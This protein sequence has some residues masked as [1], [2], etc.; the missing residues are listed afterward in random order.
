MRETTAEIFEK[1]NVNRIKVDW[2]GV[3]D[4]ACV[5][6]I[7]R[8]PTATFVPPD[9]SETGH[10]YWY[11]QLKLDIA[12]ELRK[13]FGDDLKLGPQLKR[14]G[15]ETTRR[16]S[17]LINLAMADHAELPVLQDEN[18]P[19]YQ[20]L[21]LGPKGKTMTPAERR[22]ALAGTPSYQTADVRFM[23]DCPNPL[24]ANQPGTGKTIECIGAA[25]EGGMMGLPKLI[26][27]QK[28]ALGS[29][30]RTELNRWQH[31]PVIVATGS[32]AEKMHAMR[33][34]QKLHAK[35]KPF[36]FV[37]NMEM[38]RYK[39]IYR[40]GPS[41]KKE[42]VG[43]EW[44]FPWFSE[45]PWGCV[46]VDELHRVGLNNATTLSSRAV[47]DLTTNKRIALSG[48]PMGGKPMKLW[49]A[50]HW[51]DPKEFSSKWAFANTW[52]DVEQGYG[53]S[54]KITDSIIR[55]KEDDFNRMIS[56][57]VIRRTKDEVMPWLPP[58]NE[59]DVWA[60]MDDEQRE[61]YE[62]FA[63]MAEIRIEEE[64]LTATGILAEYTRLRQFATAKQRLEI[65]RKRGPEG[66]PI[67]VIVPWPTEDSCKLP[68]VMR[69]LGEAGIEKGEV[70]TSVPGALIFSQ[71][72]KVVDMVDAY[73]H[74]LGIR[75]GKLHGGT[76][77]RGEREA[78]QEA[79]QAGRLQVLVMNT[80]AGGTSIDLQ[81]A[82]TVIF[83]DETWN[84]DDQEQASDR[85]HRGAKTDQVNVYYIRTLGTL[86]EYIYNINR[87][88]SRNNFN[89]L[90]ARRKGMR[91]LQGGVQS[92]AGGA[93]VLHKKVLSD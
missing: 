20:A 49:A 4:W 9:K 3:Y 90:D 2:G 24:N 52:L 63:E 17:S 77:K 85:G 38:V 83:L 51:L 79:F 56:R 37:C 5:D 29:V 67:E 60:E 82:N 69:I 61:Q 28:S 10:A 48:T 30:W 1:G 92:K 70:D 14:W 11:V 34:A 76:N 31:E 89:V 8:V 25:W 71:F 22:K 43:V 80:L 27:G 46:I 81:K 84:P 91:A 93:T 6:A 33:T 62:Q 13:V 12:R 26:I 55:G 41:G 72:S 36:W 18:L 86:E 7:K 87:Q 42:E 73:L 21:H 45:V 78:L 57:Y 15:K 68:H 58:K 23:A 54:R 74:K 35:G 65:G 19:L 50:L 75:S 47:S 88:K 66:E 16:E 32:A 39:G 64:E 44:A 40:V 59:M 53:N